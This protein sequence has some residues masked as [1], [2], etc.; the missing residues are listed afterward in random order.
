MIDSPCLIPNSF[1]TFG[2]GT[3]YSPC[4]QLNDQFNWFA[5]QLLTT[6]GS[7]RVAS[8]TIGWN[9]IITCP[10]LYSA[11]SHHLAA[12]YRGRGCLQPPSIQLSLPHSAW[13][14]RFSLDLSAPQYDAFRHHRPLLT[15]QA[16]TDLVEFSFS[17]FT[18]LL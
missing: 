18:Y 17:N 7:G 16:K 12:H 13:C 5:L 10:N 9:T 8:T 1:Y 11:F 14:E 15:R 2:L 4:L 3:F 6:S